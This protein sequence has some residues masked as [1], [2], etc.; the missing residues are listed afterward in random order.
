[1]LSAWWWEAA[2][3]VQMRHPQPAAAAR[4]CCNIE[5]ARVVVWCVGLLRRVR[6]SRIR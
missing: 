4:I 1:M 3:A 2:A 5:S 6:S